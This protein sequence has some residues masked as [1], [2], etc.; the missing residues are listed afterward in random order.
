MIVL[1]L[2][3][4]L[5]AAQADITAAFLH[6]SLEE[7]EEIYAEMPQGFRQEGKVYKLRRSQYGMRQIP[8]SFFKYL[9]EK[10]GACGIRQ[11]ELDPSLF[12]VRKLIVIS[13]VENLLL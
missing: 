12:I 10:L 5:T 7:G 4:V 9:C 1:S 8:R 2:M 11:P 6:S 3:L 13:W